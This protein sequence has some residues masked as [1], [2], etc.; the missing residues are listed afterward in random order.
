M[1]MKTLALLTAALAATPASA[2]VYQCR[3]DKGFELAVQAL[4]AGNRLAM[5]EGRKVVVL[6]GRGAAAAQ[7]TRTGDG[8][9]AYAGTLGAIQFVPPS[10]VFGTPAVFRMRRPEETAWTSYMCRGADA[11]VGRLFGG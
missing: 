1:E 4:A 8:G 7:C 11:A 6:C 10:G 3:S 5:H 9:Y 2:E